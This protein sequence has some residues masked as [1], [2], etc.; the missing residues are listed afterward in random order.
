MDK[1]LQLHSRVLRMVRVALVAAVYIVCTLAIAPLSYG[2]VQLRFSEVLVLLCFYKKDYCYSMILG[3]AIANLFSPLGIYD[4]VFGTLATA[5]TVLAVS[6][7]RHLLAATLFPT[8]GCVIVG[9]ELHFLTDVPFL[10]TTL[11]VMAGEFL[12]VTVCGY[13]LFK[14]LERNHGFMRMLGIEPMEKQAGN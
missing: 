5:L 3:C 6:H 4:V 9:L 10:L 1:F 8:L 14:L 7:C 2:A 11:T 12:V 13:P